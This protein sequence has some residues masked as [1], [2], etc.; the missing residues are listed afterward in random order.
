[1]QTSSVYQTLKAVGYAVLVLGG[2][3]ICYAVFIG[4]TYWTGI[5]V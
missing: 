2:A 3:S 4:I 1:M 5:G